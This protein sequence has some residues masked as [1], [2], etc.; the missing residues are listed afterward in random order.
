MA[1][2]KRIDGK[3]LAQTIV[4]E[5]TAEIRAENLAPQLAVILVGGDPASHSYVRLKEK[6]CKE[7]GISF[8]KYLIDEDAPEQEILDIVAFLN[9]DAEINAILIQL[10]LPKQFNQQRILDAMDYRK[11]V[12]GFHS[13]NIASYLAGEPQH[14]LP[15]LSLALWRLIESC[16]HDAYNGK[17]AVIIGKSAAFTEPTKKLLADN[18]MNTVIIHP[19]DPDL[20]NTTAAADIIITAVGKPRYVTAPMIKQGAIVIDVGISKV[21]G[22]TVGDV[23]FERVA[24]KTSYITPVPGGV[25]PMTVAMLLYNTVQLAKVKK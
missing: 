14:I 23:D 24:P 18:G 3:K 12:D 22:V 1:S 17:D 25:G 16:G 21:N 2:Y 5:L 6:T 13:K 8:H 7:A 15:G 10:P 9:K 20:A 11:D 19:D 4:D